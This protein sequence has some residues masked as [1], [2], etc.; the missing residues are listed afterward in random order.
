MR[1]EEN[2][3][4]NQREGKR[5]PWK[6]RDW[7]EAKQKK[8][9]K[10]WDNLPSVFFLPVNP[11]RFVHLVACCPDC[12]SRGL[13]CL[14]P[15]VLVFVSVCLSLSTRPLGDVCSHL[16]PPP[17]PLRRGKQ[18]KGKRS[19]PETISFLSYSSLFSI[20]IVSA[21][22][23]A[24]VLWVIFARVWVLLHRHRHRRL[25]GL[26]VSDDNNLAE[27]Q[28]SRRGREELMI[29]SF[30]FSASH[31]NLSIHPSFLPP[32]VY[33]MLFSA[34]F[35]PAL[36]R[37][38]R[39]F[40]F[41]SLD[42]ASPLCSLPISFGLFDFLFSCWST[43]SGPR[44]SLFLSVFFSFLF[45]CFSAFHCLCFHNVPRFVDR[46]CLSNQLLT[47]RLLCFLLSHL[48]QSFPGIDSFASFFFSF[49]FSFLLCFCLCA[50]FSLS[51]CLFDSVLSC[52]SASSY[53]CSCIFI[54]ASCRFLLSFLI[55][56][57]FFF[58]C[59]RSSFGIIIPTSNQP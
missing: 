59:S 39:S 26:I 45:L 4:M 24:L 48:F 15:F 36:P 55:N 20:S 29:S 46:C 51:F 58:G 31:L 2:K 41:H 13:V 7:G 38:F 8:S 32:S 34:S 49:F 5:R 30:S 54:L 22:L 14:L 1:R 43:S 50:L 37:P 52:F 18:R 17:P 56:L 47:L 25:V 11:F 23:S 9:S 28:E 6:G 16:N 19:R 42:F 44:L 35:S 27:E 21:C 57:R 53:S 12:W 40:S 10:A 33:L 3:E